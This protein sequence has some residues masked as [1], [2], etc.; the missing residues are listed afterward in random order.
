MII[1]SFFIV[2]WFMLSDE[3]AWH[4]NLIGSASSRNLLSLCLSGSSKKYFF[5]T[6][7]NT[8]TRYYRCYYPSSSFI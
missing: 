2:S 8:E 3:S 7:Y 5:I 1:E 6:L 4:M